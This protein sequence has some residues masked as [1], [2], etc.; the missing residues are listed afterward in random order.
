MWMIRNRPREFLNGMVLARDLLGG[1]RAVVA[2][3]KKHPHEIAVLRDLL[4]PGVELHLMG[5]Y[6]P[7]GDEHV[8]VADLLGKTVPE[9]GIPIAVGAV[10][11]NVITFVNVADAADRALP[12]PRATSRWR[13][14][15]PAVTAI[16]RSA[17]PTPTSRPRRSRRSGIS[18]SS[19]AAR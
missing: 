2:I 12:S 5:N 14:R 4:P 13:V 17:P 9:L 8:I 3:K 6:Y 10:V 16:A 15:W 1:S 19:S 7:A 18:A 11:N